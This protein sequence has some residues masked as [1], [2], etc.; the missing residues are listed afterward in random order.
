MGERSR[1]EMENRDRMEAD[2]ARERK[3]RDAGDQALT[4]AIRRLDDDEVE[5]LGDRVAQLPPEQKVDFLLGMLHRVESERD[6]FRTAATD[7]W[8]ALFAVD[9]VEEGLELLSAEHAAM[10]PGT[11]RAAFA[12][13]NEVRGA[14]EAERDR[15]RRLVYLVYRSTHDRPIDEIDWL[16]PWARDL[17]GETIEAVKRETARLDQLDG[18]PVMGAEHDRVVDRN[19]VEAGAKRATCRWCHEP[20]VFLPSSELPGAEDAWVH[21]GPQLGKYATHQRAC[22]PDMESMLA[23]PDDMSAGELSRWSAEQAGVVYT[24]GVP[25]EGQESNLETGRSPHPAGRPR[26]TEDPTGHEVPND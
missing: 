12:A 10:I 23:E 5:A 8:A 17:L 4:E 1:E 13:A 16:A 22:E 19:A 9:R 25:G 15:L 3:Q 18:S 14:L 7:T 24:G 11:V 26:H 21:E 20:I 6:Q 2:V